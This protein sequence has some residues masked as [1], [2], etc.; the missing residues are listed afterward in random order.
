MT[1]RGFELKEVF[2]EPIVFVEG[3]NKE[4]GSKSFHCVNITK[5]KRRERGRDD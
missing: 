1:E 4:F 3:S 5:D 2:F